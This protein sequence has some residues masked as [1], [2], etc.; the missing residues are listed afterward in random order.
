LWD[1]ILKKYPA[2]NFSRKSVYQIWIGHCS[3]QWKR[4]EDEVK[5]AN[6]LLRE[7]AMLPETSLY[8]VVE[9]PLTER[10]GFTAIALSLPQALRQFGG[11]IREISLDSACEYTSVNRH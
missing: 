1:E 2:P 5:S 6:K 4:D 10:D 3:Q 7:A 9:I 11:K 8:Q